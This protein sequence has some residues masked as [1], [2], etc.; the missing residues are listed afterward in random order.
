M[1]K[2]RLKCDEEQQSSIVRANAQSGQSK[3]ALALVMSGRNKYGKTEERKSQ[4]RFRPLILVYSTIEERSRL[5]V[6]LA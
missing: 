2:W 6:S 3:L 4:I 5:E 1:S